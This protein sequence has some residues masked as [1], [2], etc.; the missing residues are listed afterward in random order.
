MN[1]RKTPND[2]EMQDEHME[3]VENWSWGLEDT[4][5]EEGQEKEQELEEALSVEEG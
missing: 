3:L 2:V 4:K 5:K 1:R